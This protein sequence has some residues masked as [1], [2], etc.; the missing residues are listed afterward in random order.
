MQLTIIKQDAHVRVPKAYL[1]KALIFF[2]N[3]LSKK[4]KK[5]CLDK[6]LTL[7]FVSKAAIKSLNQQFRGKDKPTDVLSFDPLEPSSLGELTFS[8]EVLGKQAEEHDLSFRDELVYMLYHG[9]LHLCGY[10][11]EESEKEAKQMFAI[12]DKAFHDFLSLEE[13]K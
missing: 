4:D 7:V 5:K 2:L 10:D 11:H 8:A 3:Q 9:V 13:A 6:E 12:Q 1:E